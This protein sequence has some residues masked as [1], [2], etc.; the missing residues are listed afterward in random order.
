M[1]AWADRRVAKTLPLLSAKTLYTRWGPQGQVIFG[2]PQ[3]GALL[4]GGAIQRAKIGVC[5][6]SAGNHDSSKRVRIKNAGQTT[7]G[8]G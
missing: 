1:T 7:N 5:S 4:Q 2:S 3:M 8:T 6:S